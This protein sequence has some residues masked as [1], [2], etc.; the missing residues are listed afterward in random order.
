MWL[1]VF[2]LSSMQS[3][4]W[5]STIIHTPLQISP[6]TDSLFFFWS[7]TVPLSLSL[8]HCYTQTHCTTVPGSPFSFIFLHK[9]PLVTF[10]WSVYHTIAFLKSDCLSKRVKCSRHYSQYTVTCLR[11]EH[12][13]CVGQ[14]WFIVSV[15]TDN[16][17]LS[18]QHIQQRDPWGV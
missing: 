11:T 12:H 15:P 4:T 1:N 5:P 8:T 16:H 6:H 9:W 14:N 18:G 3:C 10:H 13:H 2:F 17:Q 7:L